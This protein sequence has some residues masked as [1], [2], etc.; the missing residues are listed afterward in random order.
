MLDG[1]KVRAVRGQEFGNMPR[2]FNSLNYIRPF[3]KGGIVHYDDRFL[4][5]FR[6][7]ILIQPGTKH[8]RVDIAAEQADC[9]EGKTYNRP[10]GID[11]ASGMP[12]FLPVTSSAFSGV[13]VCPRAVH[14]ETALIQIG[15]RQAQKPI[16]RYF[17]Q[18]GNTFSVIGRGVIQGFFY[19]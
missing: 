10:Y 19:R 12:V 18:E 17:T 9:Q 2:I 5:K 15:D 8:I 6:Y 14:G 3:V 4:G 16:T 13:S 1:I 11:P 7:K